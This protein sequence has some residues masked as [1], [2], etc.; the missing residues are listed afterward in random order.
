MIVWC[1]GNPKQQGASAHSPP[2]FTLSYPKEESAGP[3]SFVSI[4]NPSTWPS[5]RSGGERELGEVCGCAPN[6][7]DAG[8]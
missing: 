3:G 1:F 8:L 4:T 2:L 7:H 5:P 6:N